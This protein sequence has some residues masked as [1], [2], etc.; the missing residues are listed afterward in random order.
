MYGGPEASRMRRPESR[1]SASPRQK[2]GTAPSGRSAQPTRP[3]QLVP[4]HR[5][6]GAAHPR[7]DRLAPFGRCLALRS[8]R[9]ERPPFRSSSEEVEPRG[10]T[11]GRR[12]SA[13]VL[14]DPGIVGSSTTD[15]PPPPLAGAPSSRCRRLRAITHLASNAAAG[16]S[17]RLPD[18]RIFL[19]CRRGTA[20]AKHRGEREGGDGDE[21]DPC[22]R[23]PTRRGLRRP[24]NRRGIRSG[25][26]R[27][28]IRA[29][30]SDPPAP[31]HRS[32]SRERGGA[33]TAPGVGGG[34][35]GVRSCGGVVSPVQGLLRYPC[36]ERAGAAVPGTPALSEKLAVNVGSRQSACSWHG[37]GGG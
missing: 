32:H 8:G 19:K 16:G 1:P 22:G 6:I 12:R 34:D 29:A 5:P 17:A 25:A 3:R 13:G 15:A 30:I 23:R 11:P 7:R 18:C 33:V 28:R 27:P 24:G 10:D 9:R 21:F 14:A 31:T 26:P 37:S 35:V 4:I 2:T 20:P 36:L